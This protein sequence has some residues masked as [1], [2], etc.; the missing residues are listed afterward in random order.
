M[1]ISNTAS[2]RGVAPDAIR[3][4]REVPG[5]GDPVFEVSGLSIFYGSNKAVRDVDLKVG[6]RQITAMIGPSGCGK[7]TV[8]RTLNRMNDLIPGARIEGDVTYHGEDLY[9]PHVDPIEVRRRIGMVFQKPNPFP[10]S[11]Y[12]NVAYGPRIN[13]VR[14]N[15]DDLVEET[16]TK[17][18]LWDEVKDKLKESAFALSGGQQQ[19][20]CIARTIAVNPEVILM[21]EPCSALDPIATLKIEDLMYE[22]ASEYTIVIVT[23][24]MQ[25]AARVSDRTA[26]FTAGVDD[27]GD[28]Y[29]SLV[30]FDETAKIFSKPADQRTEDYISG[31]FG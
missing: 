23:H 3:Y 16:L 13:G 18:A 29:G 31:R 30:E 12:D 24:N 2:A 25:Q 15:M 21:D 17:A 7:S 9:A 27:K 22:L 26:F 20:L 4:N 1:S 8:L 6:P 11:I 19:R 10:K 5:L 28:R 14:S